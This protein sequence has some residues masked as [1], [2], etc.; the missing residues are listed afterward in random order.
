MDRSMVL[1]VWPVLSL[2]AL[3]VGWSFPLVLSLASHIPGRGAGD[4]LV[5]V[6][7]LWWMRQVLHSPDLSFFRCPLL[8]AAFGIE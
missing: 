7:D 5:F 3:S 8:F 6:W 4:N 1:H 2:L